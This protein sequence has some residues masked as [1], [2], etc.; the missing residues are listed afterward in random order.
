MGAYIKASDAIREA[1]GCA[2]IIIHHCGIDG[3]RP[4]GHTSL[5]GAADAQLACK[6]DRNQNVELK[7]EWMK[8][9]A[10]EGEIV[11]SRLESVEVGV[12]ADGDPITSCVVVPTEA[13]AMPERGLRLTKNQETC[14]AC[15]VK[16]CQVDCLPKNGTKRQGQKVSA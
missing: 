13:A 9:G 5:T 15:C 6:R 3:T 12:D 16:E 1:F 2:V 10:S 14:T 11:T 7:V 4:R 8:D